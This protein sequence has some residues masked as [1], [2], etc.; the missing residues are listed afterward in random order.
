[1]SSDLESEFE[2]NNKK[3]KTV[4]GVEQ[5]VGEVPNRGN[6]IEIENLSPRGHSLE[7]EAEDEDNYVEVGLQGEAVNIKNEPQ[8]EFITVKEEIEEEVDK[9]EEEVA[10]EIWQEV[11]VKV[12]NDVRTT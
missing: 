8:E 1:M 3:A 10:Q 4:S 12:S 2:P 9:I 7:K 5:S 6:V 11:V